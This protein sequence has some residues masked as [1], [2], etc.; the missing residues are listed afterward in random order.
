MKSLTEPTLR[1]FGTRSTRE[2]AR[3]HWSGHGI[4][5]VTLAEFRRAMAATRRYED[6]K[7]RAACREGIA[8]AAIPQRVFDEFYR[9][10]R[11]G[12]T[13][14]VDVRP[15]ANTVSARLFRPR[16]GIS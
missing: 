8:L 2:I 14:D 12:A 3:G 5:G 11:T 1:A 10:P 15:E 13:R 4:L 9:E 16:G 7:Y 6:L